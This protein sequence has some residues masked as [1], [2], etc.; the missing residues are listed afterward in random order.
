MPEM[1]YGYAEVDGKPAVLKSSEVNL[2]IAID[3]AKDDGTRQLLVPS[4]KGAQSMDF[5]QF[6][7][8]YED[9]IRRARG[10]K[11]T[12]DDFAGHHDLASPTR[13]P[14]APCTRCRA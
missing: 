5:A 3:L 6:W 14:S 12:V 10:G 2:G 9:V 1:N 4:I 13:A 8:A 7:A 11:L